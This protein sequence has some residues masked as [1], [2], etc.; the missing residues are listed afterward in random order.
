[1]KKII[2]ILSLMLPSFSSFSA[3]TKTSRN[4]E[5]CKFIARKQGIVCENGW[6]YAIKKDELR[7]QEEYFGTIFDTNHKH[8]ENMMLTVR[9]GDNKSMYMV[10]LT[11]GDGDF[12]FCREKD[13]CKLKARF[14]DGDIFDVNYVKNS[15][16]KSAYIF[17]RPFLV[18][19]EKS[20]KIVLEIAT[21]E[22]KEAQFVFHYKRI[23]WGGISKNKERFF[24]TKLAGVDFTK[25]ITDKN[26]I[27]QSKPDGYGGNYIVVNNNSLF[28]NSGIQGNEVLLF[29]S[30]YPTGMVFSSDTSCKT[31][32]KFIEMQRGVSG[33]EGDGQTKWEKEDYDM[34]EGIS[35]V[36][37]SPLEGN[38]CSVRFIYW[39]NLFLTH[40]KYLF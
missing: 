18:A 1:M 8:N 26:I 38:G 25:K 35:T 13:N 36:I 2:L 12:L 31:I 30:G 27:S 24:I 22:K 15:N 40:T 14:D 5:M 28:V 7:D 6:I 20:S 4:D 34:G 11:M 19:L 33:V 23:R 37:T 29:N 16:G 21:G 17:T 9:S 32:N 39:A 3:E 10:S